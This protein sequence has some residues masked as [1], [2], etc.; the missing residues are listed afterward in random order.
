[1]QLHFGQIQHMINIR[2]LYRVLLYSYTSDKSS[3]C[4]IRLLYIEY[5]YIVTLRKSLANVRSA[6][7]ISSTFTLLRSVQ[8]QQIL[9]PLGLYRV[10]LYSYPDNPCKCQIR[11]LSSE[12]FYIDTLRTSLV[13]VRSACF[14]SVTFRQLHTRQTQHTLDPRALYRDF[15]D[16]SSIYKVTLRRSACF[17]SGTFCSQMNIDL[18]NDCKQIII[19]IG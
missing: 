18:S 1:M 9:D 12:Y 13:N 7:F 19:C 8:A 6:C 10:L 14:I 11:L 3:K 4:Q 16:I 17:V 15:A 2:A 5:F